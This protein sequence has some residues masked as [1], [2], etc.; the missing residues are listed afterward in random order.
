MRNFKMSSTAG[1]L[2]IAEVVKV[3][4]EPDNPGKHIDYEDPKDCD[5]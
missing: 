3:I 5:F 2:L 1:G 4:R